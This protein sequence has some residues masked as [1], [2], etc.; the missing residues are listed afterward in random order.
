MQFLYSDGNDY[1]FM[2]TESYEQFSLTAD[3]W[4]TPPQYLTDGM[5]LD[6]TSYEGETIG[7]ELPVS[8]DLKVESTEPGFAGDTATGARK[9]ATLQTGSRRAGAAVRPGRRH[10]PRRHSHRRVPDEG[11]AVSAPPLPRVD[12]PYIADGYG[13]PDH[14]DGVLPWSWAEERLTEAS[15]YWVATVL[16]SGRPHVTPIWGVWVDGAFWM[17]GGPNTRRFRNLAANPATVIT[18]ERGN[19]AVILEGDADLVTRCSDGGLDGSTARP[20]TG[21]TWPAT[22]TRRRLRTGATASGEFARTRSWAGATFRPTRPAGPSMA[23]LSQVPFPSPQAE[24]PIR[25]VTELTKLVR[26]A[27]NRSP[28]LRDVWVEGEVG[29][30]SIS[31]AGHCYFTLKDEKAQLRC[32]IF[33]DDRLMMPF[34][35]RTGLRLVA[36]G[37][38]DVFEPQGVYQLYV[39]TLQPSGFG[40]LALQ[41]EALKAK[42]AA[43]GLFDAAASG[44][45]RRSRGPSASPPA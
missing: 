31:A 25:T 22:T 43:E 34:E 8:V 32:V 19:D 5:M 16:P 42:L 7:V 9:P 13:I 40:D 30:V 18:L 28:G 44:R 2:D 10:H 15:V 1:T 36:H 6:R 26:D 24:L 23:E 29:Q 27:V 3:S 4:A 39:D 21:S 35:A 41:F 17:E 14:L 20:P 38:L 33:R 12:R 45:C 11:L 37:R